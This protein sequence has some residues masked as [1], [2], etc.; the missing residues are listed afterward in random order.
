MMVIAAVAIVAA[1]VLVT[2]VRVLVALIE[3]AGEY[4]GSY[5]DEADFVDVIDPKNS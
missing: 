2:V 4:L 1:A 5:P 3:S